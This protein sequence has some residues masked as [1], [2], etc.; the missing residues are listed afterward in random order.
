MI[1]ELLKWGTIIRAV[2]S[3]VVDMALSAALQITYMDYADE[4][5]IVSQSLSI[6]TLVFVVAVPFGIAYFLKNHINVIDETR[7][8]RKYGE[9][10]SE[11]RTVSR[12]MVTK[13]FQ[14]IV[15]TRKIIFSASLVLL[16]DFPI[17]NLA[18]LLALNLISLVCIIIWK[19][20][21]NRVTNV[22]NIVQEIL[23]MAT[24]IIIM[25]FVAM[26][27]DEETKDTLGYAAMGVISGVLFLNIALFFYLLFKERKLL[28]LKLKRLAI[29]IQSLFGVQQEKPVNRFPHLYIAKADPTINF[30]A[31]KQRVFPRGLPKLK[32]DFR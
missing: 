15:A 23:L 3:A 16:Y 8:R 5:N 24:H 27:L 21:R 20:Y 32:S 29:K 31:I 6:L 12:S 11:F 28:L 4:I 9:L 10:Y 7:F 17:Q 13:S 26:E 2:F 1:S 25:T 14:S 30:T 22:K 18:V 19:P